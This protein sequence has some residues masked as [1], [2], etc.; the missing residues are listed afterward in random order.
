MVSL[1]P[2]PLCVRKGARQEKEAKYECVAGAA[3]S[4][5][6]WKIQRSLRLLVK[7]N[8]PPHL[9]MYVGLTMTDNPIL[10]L[11]EGAF[12]VVFDCRL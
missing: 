7:W 10:L 5:L 4:W 11:V 6:Q 2:L 12:T 1:E 3:I 9:K 8:A